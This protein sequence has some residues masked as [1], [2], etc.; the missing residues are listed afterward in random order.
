MGAMCNEGMSSEKIHLLTDKY[1]TFDE[2]N[3]S[4]RNVGIESMQCV[5]GFDFSAS[6]GTLHSTLSVN[7][8]MRVIQILQPVIEKFDD[9]G[10]INAYR[11]GCIQSTDQR[12][13]P[14]YGNSD[15]YKGFDALMESYKAAANSVEQSGPTTFTHTIQKCIE[16]EKSLGGKQLIVCI[17]ITDG[18][19]SNEKLDKYWLEEA[20]KYPISFVGIGVG[21]G[22]FGILEK[23]DDT[24]VS[25][26]TLI[27]TNVYVIIALENQITVFMLIITYSINSAVHFFFTS[28][29]K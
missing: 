6:N 15:I 27:L 19:I 24:V 25:E 11:F 3:L 16:L 17:L 8:Y 4:M 2:L 28:S 20:T 10:E 5:M 23:F 29:F 14:L 26:P 12:V 9:D 21:P 13:I 1:K 22:S 18:G 7:P